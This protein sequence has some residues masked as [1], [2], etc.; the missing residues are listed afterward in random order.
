MIDKQKLFIIFFKTLFF[1]SL[2]VWLYVTA[3]QIVHPD[4]V[5]WTFTEWF[6]IRMDIV[7]ETA[8][9]S[10]LIGFLIWQYLKSK[11]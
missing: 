8:F 9:V 3:M 11:K 5:S 2:L 1:Y 6:R 10:S 4:S 7:G